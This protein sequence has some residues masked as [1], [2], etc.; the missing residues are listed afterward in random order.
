MNFHFHELQFDEILSGDEGLYK[1]LSLINQHGVV[2]VI[3]AP[4]KKGGVQL[5]E[6]ISHRL[7]SY[8]GLEWDVLVV[9]DPI[10]AAFSDVELKH[11]MDFAYNWHQAG[12]QHLHCIRNDPCV[13]GGI[14][15][16]KDIYIIAEEFRKDFPEHFHTLSTVPVIFQQITFRLRTYLE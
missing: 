4:G 5:A 6:H 3:N 14:L 2:K 11:H 12:L 16:L 9:D 7:N 15:T 13:D 8:Y 10:H 1:Y